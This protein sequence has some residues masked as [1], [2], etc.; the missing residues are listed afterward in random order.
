MTKKRKVKYAYS[1][2]PMQSGLLFQA[3]YAPDSDAYFIQNILGLEGKVDSVT[4]KSAWQLVSD[5]FDVL[6]TGFIWQDGKKPFQ[7]VLDSIPLPFIEYDWGNTE[8]E[9]QSS[10]LKEFIIFLS[11]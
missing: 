11:Y 7:Y 8:K 9:I 10:K 5:S 4:L 2:S 6:K 1:L 3:L